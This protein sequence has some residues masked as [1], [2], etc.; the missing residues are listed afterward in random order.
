[1]ESKGANMYKLIAVD[2]DETLLNNDGTICKR[3]LDA[4]QKLIE[5][6]PFRE[7]SKTSGSTRK[8]T[9]ILSVSTA[10]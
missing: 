5:T 6:P 1:M 4:V 8:R 3:N 10:V 9:S 7:R 2:L